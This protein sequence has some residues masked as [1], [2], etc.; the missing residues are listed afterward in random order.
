MTRHH[1]Q[2][3]RFLLGLA[4]DLL[5]AQPDITM[6]ELARQLGVSETSARTW[7]DRVAAGVEVEDPVAKARSY[8]ERYPNADVRMVAE[9]LGLKYEAARLY[10]RRAR[11]AIRRAPRGLAPLPQP[12]GTYEVPVFLPRKG[13]RNA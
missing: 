3:F 2:E 12:T 5:A 4:R 1:T 10:A 11:D 8:I 6:R 9:H 13:K 7:R